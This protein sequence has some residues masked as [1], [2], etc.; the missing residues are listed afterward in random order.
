MMWSSWN[1]ESKA[2][3]SIT[4]YVSA[5]CSPVDAH[6]VAPEERIAVY[7]MDGTL[8]SERLPYM[9]ICMYWVSQVLD[10]DCYS[11][12]SRE[13]TVALH[14]RQCME[15]RCMEQFQYTYAEVDGWMYRRM[16]GITDEEFR[17]NAS[18]WLSTTPVQGV[19]GITYAQTIYLP[20]IELF[21]YLRNNGFQQ[22]VLTASDSIFAQAMLCQRLQIPPDHVL[23]N[24]VKY[25]CGQVSGQKVRTSQW[26][27]YNDGSEK[28]KSIQDKIGKCPLI[29]VGNGTGDYAMM[30]HTMEGQPLNRQGIALCVLCDDVQ[31]EY[32]D[33]AKAADVAH[34]CNKNGFI[35]IS[36]QNDW[37][38]LWEK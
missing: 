30:H 35:P 2:L 10:V 6:L 18:R 28:A 29:A 13:R 38:T 32:G 19:E 4:K 31:R 16:A 12:S 21:E 11:P 37:N 26:T 9:C 14:L 27:R 7:D 1:T 24:P 34:Y 3:T 5:V 17:Q 20:M 23:G 33:T 36:I 15:H 25:E 22:Y 8:I